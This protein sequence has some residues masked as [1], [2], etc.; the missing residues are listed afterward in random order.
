MLISSFW[1]RQP[2]DD[3]SHKPSSRLSSY[4]ARVIDNAKCIL[5]TCICVCVCWSADACSHYCTDP[6]VTWGNGRRC[7]LV[8][9]YWVDLQSV[10]ALHCHDNIVPCV[11]A[12]GAHNSIAA[13]A[14][15]QWVHSCTRSMPG[16]FLPRLQL[17]SQ[18]Q[19][20]TDLVQYQFKLPGKHSVDDL[21]G[22]TLTVWQ[23]NG[24]G[25][26]PQALDC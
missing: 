23:Q 14:K 25:W 9:H 15:C 24:W 21:P 4:F 17:H 13:N 8:V 2:T 12:T 19:S 7:P 26:N 6:D 20:V 16:C 1:G 22:V 10:H 18:L 11:L 5:V 3:V